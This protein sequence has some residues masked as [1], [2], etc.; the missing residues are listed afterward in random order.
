MTTENKIK[1]AGEGKKYAA[2]LS[3]DGKWW[4]FPKAPRLLQ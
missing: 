3:K 1:P 4:S 2:R